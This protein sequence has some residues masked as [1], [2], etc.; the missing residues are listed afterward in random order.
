MSAVNDNVVEGPHTQSIT[1]TA[2][3]ADTN[4][5]GITIV[6]VTANITDNDTAGVEITQSGTTDVTEGGATDSYTVV[7]T[8]QPSSDV[9]ISFGV[10]T[11]V[12]AVN[13]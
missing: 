3:S 6:N 12:N 11:Q 5:N 1:H 7:L 8:S 13:N 4:Y 9:T 10:G 2:T